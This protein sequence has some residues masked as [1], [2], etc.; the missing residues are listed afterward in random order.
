M[1]LCGN[2]QL[3]RQLEPHLG[4]PSSWE[5]G[6]RNHL[7]QILLLVEDGL[8]WKLCPDRL[9]TALAAKLPLDKLVLLLACGT[10]PPSCG[11]SLLDL[12]IACGQASAAQQLLAQGIPPTSWTS[13]LCL[14]CAC[15]GCEGTLDMFY[16]DYIDTDSHV[17]P[18]SQRREAARRAMRSARAQAPRMA[19]G[20]YQLMRSWSRGKGGENSLKRKKHKSS[21]RVF[22][23]KTPKG[24]LG[25]P[26]SS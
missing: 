6:P 18:L 20:L 1:A 16:A 7:S 19:I 15:P 13:F 10:L 21:Y 4:P 17:A 22:R 24:S 11:L 8:Q 12:A 26:W 14:H 2:M 9:S 23:S 5:L 3:W 25:L